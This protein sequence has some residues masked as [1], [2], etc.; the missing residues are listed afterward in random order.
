MLPQLVVST[1]PTQIFWVL[2]GF[3][4]VWAFMTLV[5]SPRLKLTLEKRNLH[6]DTLVTKA[7][8]LEEKTT[9]LNAEVKKALEESQQNILQAE[10]DLNKLIKEK[11]Q[12]KKEEIY[13]H[14]VKKIKM[15]KERLVEASQKTFDEMSSDLDSLIILAMTKMGYE[16]E[17]C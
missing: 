4:C 8:E 7:N 14:S 12:K 17:H 10:I 1:F 2:L 6:V 5:V 16:N 9:A 11:N 3:F 15:Q 13:Q